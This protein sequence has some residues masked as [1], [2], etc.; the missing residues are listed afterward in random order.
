MATRS[1]NS[2]KHPGLANKTTTRRTSAEVKAAAKA[3]EAAKVAKKEAQQAR[4][5]RVA[6][7]ESEARDNED[8][9]DATPR[10][11]FVPRGSHP[12]SDT[13][14]ETSEVDGPNSDGHMYIPADESDD[15]SD[16]FIKSAEATPV[17]KRTKKGTPAAAATKATKP[18]TAGKV[19]AKANKQLATIAENSDDETSPPLSKKARMSSRSELIMEGTDSDGVDPPLKH[20]KPKGRGHATETEGSAAAESDMDVPPSKKRKLVRDVDMEQ[21]VTEKLGKKKKESV[22]EAIAAI[23]QGQRVA[24]ADSNSRQAS[25]KR[26]EVAVKEK[27]RAVVIEAKKSLKNV[28]KRFGD[29][30]QWN[31][32]GEGN[33]RKQE[34]PEKGDRSIDKCSPVKRPNLNMSHDQIDLPGD[35]TTYVT[36]SFELTTIMLTLNPTMLFYLTLS[37]PP[38]KKM[39]YSVESWA[40]S[41]PSNA[42]PASR[43]TSQANS[44]KT[45]KSST[46]RYGSTTPAL[47]SASSR[48]AGS[49]LTS[50]ITITSAQVPVKIKQDPDAI[51]T[52]NGA[53]SDHEETAG[54]ERDAAYA[55]P[56]KG[57]RRLNSEVCTSFIL[58]M[59]SPGRNPH[60]N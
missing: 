40:K 24:S 36:Y 39:K 15:A 18:G 16:D 4:I 59:N 49:I 47:T 41:I 51:Y 58:C 10:P 6:E 44:V 5:K 57:K 8:L 55:S 43:A 22:R 52:Y 21:E 25:E 34:N 7:F 56:F 37:D 14:L 31:Q 32:R 26:G 9:I 45:G 29:G 11:N 60:L 30:P 38:P 12:N 1:S 54:L 42:K 20:W 3:K 48:P 46:N 35:V 33:S 27:A 13:G 28:S 50:A 2:S 53:L 23:Q 19:G 17:P